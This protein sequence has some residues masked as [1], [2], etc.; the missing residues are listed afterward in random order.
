VQI[1]ETLK[2]ENRTHWRAWLATNHDRKTEIWLLLDIRPPEG[3]LTYLDSVEE[4]IC[5]GWID[6]I[7]KVY[8]K[9]EKAQRF[10]PR[11]KLSNWTELNKERA[12]RLIRLGLMTNAG[13]AVL[14]ELMIHFSLADDIKAAIKTKDKAWETFEA[15]PDL[16]KRVRIG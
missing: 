2:L 14:P 15:L 10:S 3:W 1:T 4:A 7:G 6:G 13:K 12:H 16:Y 11:R 9:A 8:S 5:F